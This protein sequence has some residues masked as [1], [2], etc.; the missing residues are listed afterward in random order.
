MP[1]A[2]IVELA[3]Y[4]RACIRKELGGVPPR[5]IPSS[6]AASQ[7][8][9]SFVTLRWRDGALQGCI[10][11]LEPRRALAAD[12][13]HNGLAAAFEDPRGTPLS[14][15]DLDDLNV[16]VSVLS[17]LEPIDFDGSEEGARAA[18]RP[19]I[20]GVVLAW[21]GRRGTFLPQMWGPLPTPAEFLDE[22]KMKARLPRDFWADDVQLYR[23]TVAKAVDPSPRESVVDPAE[24][25]GQ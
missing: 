13:A 6:S 25:A 17:R 16:E 15:H 24:A 10:G 4:A 22:L 14:L 19:G 8:G 20:D 23:Y 18:L 5:A 11:S 21:R 9:A 2:E 1:Q 12:V 3:Q 7:P